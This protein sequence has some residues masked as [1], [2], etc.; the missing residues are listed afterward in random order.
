MHDDMA[1]I[2]L[3]YRKVYGFERFSFVFVWIATSS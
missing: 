3:I 2:K 1:K